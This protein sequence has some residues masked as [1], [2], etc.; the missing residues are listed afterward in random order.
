MKKNHRLVS[1]VSALVGLTAL[2]HCTPANA[3]DT[4]VT[5]TV[6]SSTAN[7]LTI[8]TGSGQ[9]QLYTFAPTAVIPSTLPLG[10]QVQVVSSPGNESDVRIARV[11]TIVP[12]GAP[13]LPPPTDNVPAAV[14]SLE[15]D[16]ERQLRRFQMAITGG[17]ALDPE[18]VIIGTTA[19]LGPLWRSGL[20]FRPG[21]ELGFGEVTTMFGFNF[22]MIY[23]LPLTSASDR[24]STYFGGGVGVN[25]IN[26]GFEGEEDGDRFNFDDFTTDT[27]L[28]LVAGVKRRSGVFVELRTSVYSQPSPTLRLIVGYSF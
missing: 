12:P 19:Q 5:G 17:V 24:F 3:Q 9:F 22:E 7:T 11:V 16:I 1:L 28:N 15:R 8:R 4:A 10:T 21:F 27:A 6:A 2:I 25:L 20:Y 14:H 13:A 23:R 26:L 18:L